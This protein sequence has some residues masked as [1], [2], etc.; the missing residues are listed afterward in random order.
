M[1]ICPNFTDGIQ[2]IIYA[3]ANFR[4]MVIDTTRLLIIHIFISLIQASI[5]DIAASFDTDA[6]G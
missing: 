4:H 3:F 5:R 2:V 1:K 6:P